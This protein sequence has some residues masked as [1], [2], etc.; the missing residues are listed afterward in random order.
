MTPLWN[1]R[2][3]EIKTNAAAAARLDLE[4]IPDDV[5]QK[6]W[7]AHVASWLLTVPGAHPFWTQFVLSAVHLRE[8]PGVRSPTIHLEGATHEL[9]L[10][11][12]SPRMGVVDRVSI[13]TL[14]PPPLLPLNLVRQV[15]GATDDH[16]RRLAGQLAG[17]VVH[18][19]LHPEPGDIAGAVDQWHRT[20]DATLEHIIH[21]GHEKETS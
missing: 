12:L 19:L 8:I 11:A 7:E 3:D 21:G 18:G 14:R 2:D 9:V 17:A 16:V 20:I 5:W 6:D 1:G 15:T 10:A 13:R 4:N